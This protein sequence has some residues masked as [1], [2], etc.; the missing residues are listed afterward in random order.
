MPRKILKGN[1]RPIP[2]ISKE[3]YVNFDDRKKIKKIMKYDEPCKAYGKGSS[4]LNVIILSLRFH[5][6]KP[7][8]RWP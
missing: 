4:L 6:P 3:E 5:C 8:E 7:R 2:K 1:G